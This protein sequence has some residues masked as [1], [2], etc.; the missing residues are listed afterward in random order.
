[1]GIRTKIKDFLDLVTHPFGI[2]IERHFGTTLGLKQILNVFEQQGIDMLLD[3]GA[4]TGQYAMS[5]LNL[6]Y[7]GT[8]ISFEPLK[9]V[10]DILKSN[11][12]KYNNWRLYDRAAIGDYCG[13]TIINISEN[14]ESNSILPI[15]ET[16]LKAAPSAKYVGHVETPIYTLDSI[17]P[18]I[19]KPGN[20]ICLKID[21]QGFED[22]VLSGA[23]ESLKKIILIQLELS[24]VS[25]YDGSKTI[26]WM[27]PYLN[28]IGFEPVLFL[29]GFVD[30]TTEQIQQLEGLFIN[31]SNG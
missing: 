23:T 25:L 24:L 12:S 9:D 1:M 17:L 11:Q 13:K 5:M 6:G 4:N 30:R 22:K 19:I 27:L 28:E 3:V 14:F 29:P 8:I 31:K 10:Y 15:N 26:E 2:N 18:N 16:H 21:T 7:N 20:K